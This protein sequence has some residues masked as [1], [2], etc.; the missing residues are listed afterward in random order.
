[1]ASCGSIAFASN[2]NITCKTGKRGK[3]GPR[4][5]KG[6]AGA[7]GAGGPKGFPG[8]KGA[9]GVKGDPGPIGP[10]GPSIEKPRI[11]ERPSDATAKE[12]TVATFSCI[13]EG[14]PVPDIQWLFH[15][16]TVN[17]SNSRVK[18]IGKV[19]LQ[20]SNVTAGDAGI[21]KCIAKNF[22]GSEEA[23]ATLTVHS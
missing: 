10:P 7:P 19:G 2:K 16:K 3:A 15:G 5:P 13:A 23:T 4:G 18:V 12:K 20:I 9:K 21:V 8:V 17:S 6:D 14:Y 1:M 22:I 11:I